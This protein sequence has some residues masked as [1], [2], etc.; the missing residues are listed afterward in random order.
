MFRI[1]PETL[2][3]I[4]VRLA[5]GMAHLFANHDVVATNRQRYLRMP[6]IGIVQA[7]GMDLLAYQRD[8]FGCTAALHREGPELSIALEDTRNDDLVHGTPTTLTR[9]FLA[10][11]SRIDH[12]ILRNPSYPS[13]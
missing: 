6:V 7:L 1:S 5:L 2:N 13:R 11:H 8:K 10:K 4:N 12:W 3:P 9:P